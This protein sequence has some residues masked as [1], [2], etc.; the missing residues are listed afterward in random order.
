[1]ERRHVRIES[2]RIRARGLGAPA[3]RALAEGLGG[4]IAEA[5]ARPAPAAPGG[6]AGAMTIDLGRI[7]GGGSSHAALRVEIASRIAAALARPAGVKG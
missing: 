7:A 3:A 1:M 5:L 6:G 4:A 2:V